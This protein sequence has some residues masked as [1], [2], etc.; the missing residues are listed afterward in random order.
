MSTE[1]N[2]EFDE[3]EQIPAPLSEEEVVT[4]KP[5]SSREKTRNFLANMIVLAILGLYLFTLIFFLFDLTDPSES[6]NP[7]I[8]GIFGSLQTLIAA[9]VGFY[10]GS[11]RDS[12]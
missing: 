9:V 3:S 10:F 6:L 5:P 2:N 4:A 11:S 8:T 7:I 1:I 12:S